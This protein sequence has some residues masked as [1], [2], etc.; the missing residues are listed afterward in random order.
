MDTLGFG[1]RNIGK[2]N[3]DNWKMRVHHSAIR[4]GFIYM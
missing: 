1:R 2:W 4:K 3:F